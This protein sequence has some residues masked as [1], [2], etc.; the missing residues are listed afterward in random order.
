MQSQNVRHDDEIDLID[1]FVNLAKQ[2]KIFAVALLLAVVFAVPVYLVTPMQYT[3]SYYHEPLQ[4]SQVLPL[5]QQDY[6]P[7]TREQINER[8]LAQ[9]TNPGVMEKTL[10]QIGQIEPNDDSDQARI[11][12]AQR[13]DSY[14]N[15]LQIEKIQESF[16]SGD[17]SVQ[18]LRISF[19]VT[20]LELA[21]K[22]L[23][24]HLENAEVA[25]INTLVNEISG[26]RQL[27]LGNLER[28]VR[29]L[30]IRAEFQQQETILRLQNALSVAEELNLQSAQ[31]P[32][33]V[34]RSSEAI[35]FSMLPGDT[36]YLLGAEALA[37]MI[38]VLENQSASVL[39]ESVIQPDIE[40]P[41][42]GK[43]VLAEF[44][45]VKQDVFIAE[46]VYILP[47]DFP[48][49]LKSQKVSLMLWLVIAL[50]LGVM[51]GGI[52]AIIR[53][54]MQ[55]YQKRAAASFEAAK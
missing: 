50:F 20:S 45:A 42:S 1:L 43:Q 28:L 17:N 10:S 51:F 5:L 24:E 27:E 14:L 55:G 9:L 53:V 21:A 41:V 22:L 25:T 2:W 48:L 6:L 23:T 32:R 39:A 54:A 47:E 15:L 13:V 49:Q 34:E 52:A 30:T 37:Q 7:L 12:I 19:E 11:A 44:E 16:L 4:P 29:N 8:F 35:G 33:L 40:Q 3:A 26:L 31:L 38:S 46:S 36:L 18:G